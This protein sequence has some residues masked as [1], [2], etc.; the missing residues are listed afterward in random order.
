MTINDVI[1][2]KIICE[3]ELIEKVPEIL[4]Q[5]PG[6]TLVETERHT[7][8]YNAVNLLMEVHLPASDE[9]AGQV[10]GFDWSMAHRRGLD[11]QSTQQGFMDYLEEGSR[12]VRM[13]IILMIFAFLFGRCFFPTH[14]G[15]LS[16]HFFV[17]A[18]THHVAHGKAVG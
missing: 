10:K 1:G 17:F 8:N 15:V 11:A 6:F 16:S 9:L 7:G 13:E 14:H 12:T 18:L 2:F 5:Q 4:D 3:P